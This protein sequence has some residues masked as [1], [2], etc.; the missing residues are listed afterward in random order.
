MSEVLCPRYLFKYTIEYL[1]KQ[2]NM[3]FLKKMI[4]SILYYKVNI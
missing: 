4:D 3:I 1:G 2:K